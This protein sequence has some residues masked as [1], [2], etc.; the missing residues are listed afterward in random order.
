MIGCTQAELRIELQKD[1]L[2]DEEYC[3]GYVISGRIEA[4]IS[5]KGGGIVVYIRNSFNAS[6]IDNLS[7]ITDA[8]SQQL[9]LE[10][11]CRKS[12]SFLLCAV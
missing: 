7:T 2:K 9:W 6:I 11:Q 8:N 4:R 3:S 10:V 1:V 12:K 5:L